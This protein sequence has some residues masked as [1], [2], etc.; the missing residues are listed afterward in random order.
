MSVCV[1]ERER[2]CNAS[3]VKTILHYFTYLL[4]LSFLHIFSLCSVHFDTDTDFLPT[5]TPI[6]NLTSHPQHHPQ[7][8]EHLSSSSS[9]SFP[10]PLPPKPF[11]KLLP[12]NTGAGAGAAP[13]NEAL[14]LFR[15]FIVKPE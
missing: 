2:E 8:L 14:K 6:H 15:S 5:P 12:L 1:R 10:S 11:P 7:R 13:V 9:K 4:F 3:S